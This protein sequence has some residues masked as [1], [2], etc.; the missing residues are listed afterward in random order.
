MSDDERITAGEE[1]SSQEPEAAQFD[2]WLGTWKL[3]WGRAPMEH[4]R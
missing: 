4:T 2:F 1:R 3:N